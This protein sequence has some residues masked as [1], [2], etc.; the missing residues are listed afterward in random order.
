VHPIIVK[1]YCVIILLTTEYVLRCISPLMTVMPYN[2][3]VC[4]IKQYNISQKNNMEYDIVTILTVLTV[5]TLT[6]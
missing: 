4:V 5:V 6:L 3:D 2:C 1:C